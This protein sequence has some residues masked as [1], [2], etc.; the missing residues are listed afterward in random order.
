MYVNELFVIN[1]LNNKDRF[2]SESYVNEYNNQASLANKSASEDYKKY[3]TRSLIHR[4]FLFNNTETIN[5]LYKASFDELFSKEFKNLFLYD[6]KRDISDVYKDIKNVKNMSG[7]GIYDLFASMF[8]TITAKYLPSIEPTDIDLSL[9]DLTKYDIEQNDILSLIQSREDYV[10]PEE[11]FTYRELTPEER[12]SGVNNETEYY[13]YDNQT[14]DYALVNN[15]EEF[16]E[17]TIYYIKE[18]VIQEPIEYTLDDLTDDEKTILKKRILIQTI[19][20][21]FICK[22]KD[23]LITVKEIFSRYDLYTMACSVNIESD[24]FDK[25][26][27]KILYVKLINVISILAYAVSA[28][29]LFEDYSESITMS[30][31]N[32]QIINCLS[33]SKT[34]S[35]MMTTEPYFNSVLKNYFSNEFRN[36]LFHRIMIKSPISDSIEVGQTNVP[37]DKAYMVFTENLIV[38][39]NILDHLNIV[40]AD[41]SSLFGSFLMCVVMFVQTIYMSA[42][43]SKYKVPIVKSVETIMRNLDLPIDSK[44]TSE[45]LAKV[46]SFRQ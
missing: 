43:V 22:V 32:S 45:E 30:I 11:Q 7:I 21:E 16:D 46:I 4:G 29:D 41:M 42:Y 3:L 35:D 27:V 44:M 8:S 39:R 9:I 33:K 10:E 31:I 5:N 19:D 1:K 14:E 28:S 18:P 23:F 17:N 34:I 2:V 38:L 20:D 26:V 12:E 25:A 15:I 40:S 36:M 6:L 24:K 37:I 13:I